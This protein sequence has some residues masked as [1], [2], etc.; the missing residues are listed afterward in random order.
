[1]PS[2]VWGTA[3][4]QNCQVMVGAVLAPRFWQASDTLPRRTVPPARRPRQE[5]H[6]C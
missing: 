2:T 3:S 4:R 6:R 1:V 5:P